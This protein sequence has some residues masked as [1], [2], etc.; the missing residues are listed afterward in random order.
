M[1][2][3]WLAAVHRCRAGR[4]TGDHEEY[5]GGARVGAMGPGSVGRRGRREGAVPRSCSTQ[6]V[7]LRTWKSD[8]FMWNH[9]GPRRN[10]EEEGGM[11]EGVEGEKEGGEQ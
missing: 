8:E 9:P 1:P 6:H 2:V 4:S 7:R 3:E 10:E 5:G 11:G